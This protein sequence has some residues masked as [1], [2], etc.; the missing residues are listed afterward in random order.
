M[1]PIATD[2]A[3]SMVCVSVCRSHVRTEQKRLNW[4]RCCL[5]GWLLCAQG[6]VW[7]SRATVGVLHSIEKHCKFQLQ[8]MLQK[9]SWKC[10]VTARYHITLSSMKNLL[11]SPVMRPFVKILTL[12]IRL[13]A[14]L[15]P[16]IG[17]TLRCV[18]AV[19]THSAIIPQKVNRFG[20]NLADFGCDPR[21]S[22]S[23]RATR[24]L[25]LIPLRDV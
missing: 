21:S 15:Q 9:G 18:L 12:V 3:H 25:V 7:G 14:R 6:T 23:W 24:N 2:V 13:E 8:C 10:G 11:P 20:W 22:D 16:N 17:F 1:R 5:G 19:F 4:S